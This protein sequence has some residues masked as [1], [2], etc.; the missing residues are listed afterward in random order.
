MA[1]LANIK[2]SI[3]RHEVEGLLRALRVK[4]PR[5][6]KTPVALSGDK[7]MTLGDLVNNLLLKEDTRFQ[8]MAERHAKARDEIDL[9]TL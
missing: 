5:T 1:N 4:R 3:A 6:L 2:R 8:A 9:L 7:V